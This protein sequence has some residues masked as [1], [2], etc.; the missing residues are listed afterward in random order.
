MRMCFGRF[1]Y[2]ISVLLMEAM[3]LT[4]DNIVTHVGQVAASVHLAEETGYP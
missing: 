3:V 4:S 2:S 1:K